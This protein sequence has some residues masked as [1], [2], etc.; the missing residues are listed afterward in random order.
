MLR[1]ASS[2]SSSILPVLLFI[3]IFLIASLQQFDALDFDADVHGHRTAPVEAPTFH[4]PAPRPGHARAKRQAL[5][6]TQDLMSLADMI[7]DEAMRRRVKSAR[8]QLAALG[9][10]RSEPY[11]GAVRHPGG[12][13]GQDAGL[14]DVA[15]SYDEWDESA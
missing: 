7:H 15:P 2:S 12:Y 10:K 8:H 13:I 6:V 11:F 5:S 1:N 14:Y 9:R 3:V 4:I